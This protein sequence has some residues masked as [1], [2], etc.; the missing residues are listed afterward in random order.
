MFWRNSSSL[1]R[2][3]SSIS[4]SRPVMSTGFAA[5]KGFDLALDEAEEVGTGWD[6][7]AER[8]LSSS[9]LRS[10]GTEVSRPLQLSKPPPE[11][12][13]PK[14]NRCVERPWTGLPVLQSLAMSPMLGSG[15]ARSVG[16][17]LA[18]KPLRTPPSTP[19]KSKPEGPSDGGKPPR[20]GSN[21]GNGVERR[22]WVASS[23]IPPVRGREANVSMRE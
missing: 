20:R 8:G 5:P 18:P 21:A 2:I 11:G 7:A 13:L 23:A 17:N 3:F 6:A 10:V 22:H 15:G 16:V 14:P 1:S 19:I 12:R 4:R 9:F